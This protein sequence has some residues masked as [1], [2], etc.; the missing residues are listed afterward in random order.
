ML[1]LD[2]DNIGLPMLTLM[3]VIGYHTDAN[4]AND[5]YRW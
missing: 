5:A 2:T 1:A 4:D 3:S